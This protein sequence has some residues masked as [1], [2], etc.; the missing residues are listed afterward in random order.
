[1]GMTG[2]PFGF[3]MEFFLLDGLREFELG[4][5]YGHKDIGTREMK[6][7]RIRINFRIRRIRGIHCLCISC[8]AL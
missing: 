8:L 6:I 3:H 7:V 4:Y 1:M 5:R 2:F